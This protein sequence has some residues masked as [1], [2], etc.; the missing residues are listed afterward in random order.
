VGHEIVQLPGD[1][2]ALLGHRLVRAQLVLALEQ[3]GSGGERFRAHLAAADGAADEDHREDREPGEDAR[4][5]DV[6]VGPRHEIGQYVPDREDGHAGQEAAP[7]GPH[8]DR[9]QRAHPPCGLGHGGPVARHGAE[10]V[11]GE[12]HHGAHAERPATAHRDGPRH[13]EH[14]GDGHALRA[15]D[16]VTHPELDLPQDHQA[17]GHEAVELLALGEALHRCGR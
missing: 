12:D 9:V 5:L 15:G 10:D 6:R 17:G 7:V 14:R 13:D 8:G 2:G 4:V 3:L 11:V 16:G 1:A